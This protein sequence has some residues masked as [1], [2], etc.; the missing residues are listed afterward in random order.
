MIKGNIPEEETSNLKTEKYNIDCNSN[1]RRNKIYFIRRKELILILKS[2]NSFLKHP[3]ESLFT[4]IY[5]MDLIFTNENLEKVFC[6]H[7][8]HL[9]YL[10]SFNDI[11]MNN[12]ALLA[13]GCLLVAY[14]FDEKMPILPTMPSFANLLY[15]FS[16]QK[17]FFRPLDFYV[18]EIVVVKLLKYKLTFFSIFHFFEF[19]F[20]HGIIFNR[21]LQASPMYGRCPDEI[22]L[23]KI[24]FLAL[25]ILDS[26]IESED[27]FNYYFGKNNYL[28]VSEIILWATER[29]LGAQIQTDENIFKL[30]Y[31]IDINE[32][33]KKIFREICEKFYLIKKANNKLNIKSVYIN[34]NLNTKPI[35]N[36]PSENTNQFYGN[37][38]LQNADNALYSVA[39]CSYN[40]NKY[41]KF[42]N[43]YVSSDNELNNEDWQYSDVNEFNNPNAIKNYE[44]FSEEGYDITAYIPFSSSSFKSNEKERLPYDNKV[45]KIT[46]NNNTKVKKISSNTRNIIINDDDELMYE[47]KI[48]R[49]K[50][51]INKSQF[52]TFRNGNLKQNLKKGGVKNYNK[53]NTVNPKR[54]K[55]IDTCLVKKISQEKQP[56]DK[57]INNKNKGNNNKDGMKKY[58]TIII[59]N[60]IHINNYY[61]NRTKN[62]S[63]GGGHNKVNSDIHREM[64]NEQ[65]KNQI[66]IDD[67]FYKFNYM[68]II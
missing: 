22:L 60:N 40:N 21:T 17:F 19:F 59:N 11:E 45:K 30:I 43:S 20:T 57:I 6:A 10:N 39:S 25:E 31:N 52:M 36:N 41:N 68:N 64:P 65:R 42:F 13:I 27:Y 61:G 28:I 48:N 58:K 4:A 37:N 54:R 62:K 35:N 3:T 34:Q 47:E 18:A 23:E 51:F 55:K 2:I 14:K 12:Y 29:T 5:Y 1:N 32:N 38:F 56:L 33:Q 8:N 26:L 46:K 49:P 44:C 9:S 24:Y 66:K 16:S 53:L 67:G 15:D 7:F 50:I 63:V